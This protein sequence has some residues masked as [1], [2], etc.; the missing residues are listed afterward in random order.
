[1]HWVPLQN[2]MSQQCCDYES[3]TTGTKENEAFH[4]RHAACMF[5]A[6]AVLIDASCNIV[7]WQAAS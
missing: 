4:C 5:M 1:M 3:N 6:Y 7:R 2:Q